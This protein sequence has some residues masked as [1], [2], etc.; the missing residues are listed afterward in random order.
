MNNIDDICKLLEIINSSQ[1]YSVYKIISEDSIKPIIN[2]NKTDTHFT[3]SE[4]IPNKSRYN[5]Y[6]SFR[7]NKLTATLSIK[8][9][10]DSCFKNRRY[11]EN[12]ENI[13]KSKKK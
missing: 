4:E 1:G 13:S 6:I 11:V 7:D 5:A 2:F 8:S 3:Y 12:T 10:N 9:Q